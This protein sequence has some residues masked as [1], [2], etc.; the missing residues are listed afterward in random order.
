MWTLHPSCIQILRWSL[1][2]SVKRTWTGYA[3]STNESVGSCNGQGLSVSCVKWPQQTNGP[4]F[5]NLALF[6]CS[7]LIITTHCFAWHFQSKSNSMSKE[8]LNHS[9]RTLNSPSRTFRTVRIGQGRKGS[10]PSG[11]SNPTENCCPPAR[12]ISK[13]LFA[14][15]FL[16][17]TN[18]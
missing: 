7:N 11:K 16:K 5:S 10:Y 13:K 1:K 9:W 12:P 4:N 17:A 18:P 8:I 14:S 6:S 2:H 3:F 15:T